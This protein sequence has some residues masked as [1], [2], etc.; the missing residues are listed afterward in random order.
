LRAQAVTRFA[1]FISLVDVNGGIAI[2][3]VANNLQFLKRLNSLPD[4]EISKA[5]FKKFMNH[6][7]A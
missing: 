4:L 6:L 5:A 2:T 1:A 3:A 7:D